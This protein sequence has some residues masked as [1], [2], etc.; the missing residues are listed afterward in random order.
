MAARAF[1][2]ARFAAG[3]V[4]DG[5]F[6]LER[7]IGSGAVGEV[8]AATN[9]ATQAA[10]A[11]KLVHPASVSRDAI[12]RFRHEAALGASFHH[13]NIVKVL[14]FVEERDGTLG[15]VMERLLGENL[16]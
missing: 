11:L 12:A 5:R 3:A 1:A 4:I 2:A 8:W 7:R 10:V 15:L 13:R 6:V 14:D 16:R 9:Q